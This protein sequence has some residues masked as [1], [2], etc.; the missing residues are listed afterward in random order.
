MHG[1]LGFPM[2]VIPVPLHIP[3]FLWQV[4]LLPLAKYVIMQKHSTHL[5]IYLVGCSIIDFGSKPWSVPNRKSQFKAYI[6]EIHM[7]LRLGMYVLLCA[8]WYSYKFN[9]DSS[10]FFIFISVSFSLPVTAM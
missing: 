10:P 2:R 4:F 3:T 9:L 8:P 7:S 6:F 1:Q 5:F